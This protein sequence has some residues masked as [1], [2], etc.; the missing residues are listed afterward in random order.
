MLIACGC[1]SSHFQSAWLEPQVAPSC[2]PAPGLQS[3]DSWGPGDWAAN[4]ALPNQL[5]CNALSRGPVGGVGQYQAIVACAA[6]A[7]A[8]AAD[9]EHLGADLVGRGAHRHERRDVEVERLDGGGQRVAV[10][11]DQRAVEGDADGPEVGGL[12]GQE[13]SMWSGLMGC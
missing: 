4:G 3:P 10:A 13:G 9:A 5:G 11:V 12:L 8:A 1:F 2:C 6:G 7:A